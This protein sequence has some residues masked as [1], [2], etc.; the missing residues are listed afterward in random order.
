MVP[1]TIGARHGD[2]MVGRHYTARRTTSGEE[3]ALHVIIAGSGRVGSQLATA[4]DAGGHSVVIIDKNRLAFRWLAEDFGGQALEGIAFDRQTLEKAGIK[5]AQAFIA[6]TSGDNSN[7]VSA[8]T[9]K[10]RYGVA[11]VVA[12]IFDPIRAEIY[13]RHGITT[14]ASTRWT[15]EAIL[16]VVLPRN[17]SI[18]GMLGPGGGDVVLLDIEVP[19]FK[20]PLE[21]VSLNQPGEAVL[22]AFSR[23]GQ[24]RVPGTRTLLQP[25]D[26]LHLAVQRDALDKVRA[27]V[28]SLGD[29]VA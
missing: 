8:R 3:A 15:A 9:A 22:A 6:V 18:Q 28:R 17:E 5:H 14:I 2:G 25:G 4:L 26:R 1:C 10:D 27:R 16:R 13:E 20:H 19:Q 11:Q 29:E 21:A 7:I 24:T 23:G 12:R